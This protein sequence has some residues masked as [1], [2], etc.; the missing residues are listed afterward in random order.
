MNELEKRL[1]SLTMLAWSLHKRIDN[2]NSNADVETRNMS[3]LLCDLADKAC[4]ECSDLK[5]FLIA[6]TKANEAAAKAA[7]E[8][9]QRRNNGGYLAPELP[10]AP[11]WD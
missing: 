5:D 6:R 7:N 1:N 3:A 2:S 11:S 10:P 8:R 9:E 4:G